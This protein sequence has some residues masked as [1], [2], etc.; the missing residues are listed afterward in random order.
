MKYV[1]VPKDIQIMI[2]NPCPLCRASV[3]DVNV[4]AEMWSHARYVDNIILPDP[5]IGTE[6]K[7]LKAC[8]IM[9]AN[10]KNAIVGKCVEVEDAHWEMLK[11]AIENPKG[12]GI[13]SSILRQ[14]L[15]FMDAVLEAKS[16][17]PTE[18]SDTEAG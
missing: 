16:E 11:T 8:S 13:S 10:F 15:P 12:G 3:G 5:A 18:Q 7:S 14:F 6:Y 9:D 17:K 1:H 2:P 4:K